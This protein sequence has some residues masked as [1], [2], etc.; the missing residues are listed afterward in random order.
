ME[1]RD[2]DS[3]KYMIKKE[4]GPYKTGFFSSERQVARL[5][6]LLWRRGL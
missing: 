2:V 1:R 5:F 4:T 6:G 3:G